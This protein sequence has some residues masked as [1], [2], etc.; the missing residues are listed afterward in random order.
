[1]KREEKRQGSS[2]MLLRL[3]FIFEATEGLREKRESEG[4]VKIRRIKENT[5]YA[6]FLCSEVSMV[7]KGHLIFLKYT[8]M[9]I[10]RF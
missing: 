6:G 8:T 9:I 1:M 4:R 10:R 3:N 7:L 5:N 2:G